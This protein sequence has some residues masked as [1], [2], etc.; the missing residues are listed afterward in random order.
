MLFGDGTISNNNV[1]K[2]AHCMEQE[3]YLKWK[4]SKL[5]SF[6]VRNNGLKT[7][8]SSCGYNTGKTV[9]YTQLNIVPF[10]K[11]LRRVFYRPKKIIGNSKMISRIGTLGLAIWYMDDGHINY[12]K[13]NGTVRGFYIKIATC[14]PKEETQII[15]DSILEEFGIKFY[16]FK[17]GPGYSLCC[18]TT[19]GVKFINI[20]KKH[21]SEVPCMMHKIQ[22]DLSKRKRAL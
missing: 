21:V 12:R 11:V 10:I 22:F 18:G 20:V 4:I 13:T 19:E 16:M 3:D 15:I 2:I 1:F 9:C 5:N 14:T 8:T 6:G 7:Y 17:E